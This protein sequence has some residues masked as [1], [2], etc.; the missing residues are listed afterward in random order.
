MTRPGSRLSA[1]FL[2]L[3][4]WGWIGRRACGQRGRRRSA[5]ELPEQ[6]E[7]VDNGDLGFGFASAMVCGT[8]EKLCKPIDPG[9]NTAFAPAREVGRMSGPQVL[10]VLRQGWPRFS[11]LARA[12]QR[13]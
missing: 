5:A 11:S 9:L 2:R 12:D 10:W 8:F 13:R 1:A 3:G 4:R 6:Q 7:A